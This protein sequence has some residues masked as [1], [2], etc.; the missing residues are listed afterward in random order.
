MKL[1]KIIIWGYKLHSH[2]HSNIHNAFYKTFT[3]PKI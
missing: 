2:T 3:P 1:N